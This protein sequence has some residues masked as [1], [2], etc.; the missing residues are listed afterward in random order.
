MFIPSIPCAQN[1]AFPPNSTIPLNGGGLGCPGL[2]CGGGCGLGLFDSGFDISQWGIME[3]LT[4]A[5]GLYIVF[6]VF[7]TTKRGVAAARELPRKRRKS[8]AAR[9]R[10]KAQELSKA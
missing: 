7:S 9:L 2:C 1:P 4:V 5:G 6:S 10:A 8:R 3:W